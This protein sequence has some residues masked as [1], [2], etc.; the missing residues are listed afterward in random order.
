M[1]ANP[2][3]W[4]LIVRFSPCSSPFTLG[5]L[6]WLQEGLK[7]LLVRIFLAQVQQET[8]LSL[9]SCDHI[10][11]LSEGP[12]RLWLEMMARSSVSVPRQEILST[13]SS[14]DNLWRLLV[15]CSAKKWS[16]WNAQKQQLGTP[17]RQSH[18]LISRLDSC[19]VQAGRQSLLSYQWLSILLPQCRHAVAG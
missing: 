13:W 3:N 2:F 12:Y 8:T 11:D 19:G 6:E 17:P 1:N 4:N 9:H 10:V 7:G 18:H 14:E 5:G 15:L 16:F